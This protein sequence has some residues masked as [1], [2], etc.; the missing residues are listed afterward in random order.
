MIIDLL[1]HDYHLSL[2][3]AVHRTP[4]AAALALMPAARERR[5]GEHKGPDFADR[6]AATLLEREQQSSP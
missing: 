3:D 5:G 4:F 1:V 6:A 2:F